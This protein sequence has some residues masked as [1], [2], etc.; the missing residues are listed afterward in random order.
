MLDAR[1]AYFGEGDQRFE[2]LPKGNI[3]QTLA[4][5]LHGLYCRRS[6]SQQN[7]TR[8][9][10]GFKSFWCARIIIAG[11]ETMHMIKKGQVHCPNSQTMSAADQFY[12]LA[13]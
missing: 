12:G 13:F 6:L 3:E 7:L 9:M 1:P 4:N 11:L 8:P 10:L 2:N 5:I